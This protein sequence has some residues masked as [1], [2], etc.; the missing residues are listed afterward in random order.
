MNFIMTPPTK[1]DTVRHLKSKL[2][3]LLP[4]LNMMHHKKAWFQFFATFLTRRLISIDAGTTP[5]P[6]KVVVE[7]CLELSTL[8]Y[9]LS[10]LFKFSLADLNTTYFGVAGYRAI[11]PFMGVVRVSP[12]PVTTDFT[13]LVHPSLHKLILNE[14]PL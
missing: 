5:L 2:R 4:R 8:Q 13:V 11:L 14:S 6:V 9:F 10:R 3:G 1:S 12:I 7:S